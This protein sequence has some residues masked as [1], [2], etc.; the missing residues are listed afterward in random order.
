MVKLRNIFSTWGRTHTKFNLVS[1]DTLERNYVYFF[2]I[3]AMLC[4]LLLPFNPF[5]TSNLHD[6]ARS[7][8]W[9]CLKFEIVKIEAKNQ[10]SSGTRYVLNKTQL[11]AVIFLYLLVRQYLLIHDL[12]LV[13]SSICQMKLRREISHGLETP[14]SP[15]IFRGTPC[16]AL[17]SSI[18]TCAVDSW[19]EARTVN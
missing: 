12:L 3:F 2:K 19:Y 8:L 5:H 4:D 9:T 17:P 13:W 10:S 14:N 16:F 11:W 1:L 15:V 6:R 7:G 18:F